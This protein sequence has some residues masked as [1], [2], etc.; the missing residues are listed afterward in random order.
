MI[1]AFDI[2]AAMVTPWLFYAG[3]AAASIPIIIHLLAKRR[4]RRI[5]WAAL[6]ISVAALE[7]VS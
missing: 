5:R 4:F 6:K 7:I 1:L 2:L 3:T